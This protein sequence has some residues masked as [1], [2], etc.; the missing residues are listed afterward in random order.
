[1]SEIIDTKSL[2]DVMARLAAIEKTMADI[3]VN[4]RINVLTYAIAGYVVAMV[5][6]GERERTA[7]AIGK[8]LTFV[9]LPVMTQ[10]QTS[11]GHDYETLVRKPS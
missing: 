10:V 3:D 8:T 11:A 6:Q 7:K 9:C 1:M 4:E 2:K 5:A